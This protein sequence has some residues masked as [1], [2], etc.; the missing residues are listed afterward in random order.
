MVILFSIVLL[1]HEHSST[2][3]QEVK[4]RI[5]EPL[6]SMAE[7]AFI[8]ETT[9][10]FKN[11]PPN[12]LDKLLCQRLD[13]INDWT[14]IV[15][16][17]IYNANKTRAVLYVR[18]SP[19]IILRTSSSFDP[20]NSIDIKSPVFSTLLSLSEGMPIRISGHFM[21]DANECIQ[22]FE[23]LDNGDIEDYQYPVKFLTITGYSS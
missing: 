20:I 12:N 3:F 5:F 17:I 9:S 10:Y 15:D 21:L 2:W 6:P 19:I 14:G 8:S 16:F 4:W 1:W 23:K 13:L 22:R 7:K 18:I 11:H